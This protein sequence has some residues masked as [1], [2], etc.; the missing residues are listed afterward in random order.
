LPS[1][2][3]AKHLFAG[4]LAGAPMGAAFSGAKVTA[5][6]AQ[7]AQPELSDLLRIELREHGEGY[8]TAALSL[9]EVKEVNFRE[10]AKILQQTLTATPASALSEFSGQHVND[11]TAGLFRKLKPLTSPVRESYLD[12]LDKMKHPGVLDFLAG[13]LCPY[14]S[15]SWMVFEFPEWLLRADVFAVVELALGARWPMDPQRPSYRSENLM[16]DTYP[17]YSTTSRDT[18]SLGSCAPR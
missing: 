6:L 11:V 2:E 18:S 9:A 7:C 16:D 17:P 13:L 14:A 8:L 15:A 10:C 5:L 1:D 3:F 4:W 12:A